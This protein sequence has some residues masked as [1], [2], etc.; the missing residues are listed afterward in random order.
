MSKGKIL[1]VDDE[2]ELLKSMSKILAREGYKVNT[3]SSGEGALLQLQSS[4]E[5]G[6]IITDISMPGIGGIELLRA[7]IKKHSHIPIIIMTAHATMNSAIEALRAGACDYLPK[8]FTNDQLLLT[9]ERAVSNQ[10]LKL[11]NRRLRA[12]IGAISS[13]S[14]HNLIGNSE[15]MQHIRGLL[16]RVAPTNLSVLITGES[17]TGK[18]VV[19]KALHL[20]STR[21]SHEFVPVDCATIPDSLMESE[22]FGHEKGAFTGANSRRTGLVETA[23]KGTFFLDE[24]GE[25]DPNVQVK[26]LRLLQEREFRRVGGTKV[27]SADIRII[28]ATNRDLDVAVREGH[29]R[30]DLFHRLNVVQIVIPPLRDRADDIPVLLK[31]FLTTLAATQGRE[32]IQCSQDVLR[33]LSSYK[34]PG[35]VRE[36]N[37]CARYVTGLTVGD[38]VLIRD[39]PPRIKAAVSGFKNHPIEKSTDNNKVNQVIHTS[40]QNIRYDLTYK[41][42]KRLWLEVFEVAFIARLLEKHGGNISH[43]ARS[44]GI[45]RK[46]IQRLMKRNNMGDTDE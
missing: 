36:L 9:V 41:A 34:W 45:D 8:P 42:A 23:N 26:L 37:N 44:A 40:S 19:A 17:G 5:F 18:E 28:A 20:M 35:N 24:I 30:E 16:H 32:P 6:L 27:L 38:T 21:A 1:L 43:A 15:A 22:L 31:H 39:L 33:A 4:S 3:A 29:F 25:L 13:E 12:Q 11:E 10:R 2:P 46:S 7:V 14:E